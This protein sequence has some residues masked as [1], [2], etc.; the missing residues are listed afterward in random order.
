MT[1]FK[2]LNLSLISALIFSVLFSM[3][4]FTDSCE[5]MYDNII[6]IRILANSDDPRDQALKIDVRDSVLELSK[7]MYAE[8]DTYDEAL[9]ETEQN[10]D[11]LLSAAQKTVKEKGLDYNVSLEIREEFFETRVYDDFTLP[12]GKYRTA[13]FTIGEGAG[14]NWW[15]VIFPR[16]CVGACSDKLDTALSEDSANAA[17]GG[18]KYT[19]K[20][21]TVE[22]FQKIK[23]IFNF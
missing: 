19:V 11:E 20:F 3:L 22:I 1:K 17:Y 9:L 16:V 4:G 21:K 8:C 5:E 10:F 2:L 18:K 13:V 7:K 6:R 15:C 12:A 23:K 14:K